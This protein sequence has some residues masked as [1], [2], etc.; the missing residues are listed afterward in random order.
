MSKG[1]I[2]AAVGLVGLGVAL[3]SCG[4]PEPE[5]KTVTKTI[6]KP[7][8]HV[9][10]KTMT[11]TEPLSKACL[12]LADLAQ[13]VIESTGDITSAAGQ[14]RDA[15][16]SAHRHA[17]MREVQELVAD[18]DQIKRANDKMTDGVNVQIPDADKLVART[19]KCKEEM[20]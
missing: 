17:A 2:I 7:V 3:G 11:V 5:I 4:E 13:S 1:I 12:D 6:E 10:T 18:I 8:T 16:D 14:I 20:K 19:E 15:A 9:E